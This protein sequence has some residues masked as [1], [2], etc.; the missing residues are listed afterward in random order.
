MS[1]IYGYAYFTAIPVLGSMLTPAGASALTAA[2]ITGDFNENVE[3]RLNL[4]DVSE[5]G[6]L[7]GELH[8]D[9]QR[10]ISFNLKVT[11]AFVFPNLHTTVV[12]AGVASPWTR[13]NGNW[14]LDQVDPTF[15]AG[16]A[17]E[18]KVMLR[19]PANVTVP[20]PS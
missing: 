16:D 19:K 4:E 8:D 18:V 2:R 14:I 5:A 11:S 12:I 10:K 20:T 17:A 13:Y 15:K 1:E 7:V 3:H 9:I 6:L